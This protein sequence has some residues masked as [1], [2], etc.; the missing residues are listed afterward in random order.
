V[1]V[2]FFGQKPERSAP[3]VSTAQVLRAQGV[4][5]VFEEPP[6]RNAREWVGLM[7]IVDV[8]ICT[9]YGKWRRRAR[10]IL[11]QARLAAVVGTPLLRW[12][13]GSDVW[14]AIRDAEIRQSAKALDRFVA[15]NV[16]VS[17]HLRDEL[18]QLGIASRV[19][20]RPLPDLPQAIDSHW[21]EVR[22][23]SVLVY[24]PADRAAS[25]GA[26][27]LDALIPARQDLT[28]YLVA[29]A[30]QRYRGAANVVSLGWIQDMEEAYRQTG[31]LMRLRKH[32]GLSRMV[33]EALAR[34]LYVIWSEPFEGC[35]L[36]RTYQEVD[37]ALSAVATQ[38]ALNQDG[39]KVMQRL[40]QPELF[41]QHF[42][43]L[44]DEVRGRRWAKAVP[45]AV[46]LVP[47]LPRGLRWRGLLPALEQEGP[48]KEKR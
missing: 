13:V 14:N 43:A 16:V 36:A 44:V 32:D 1:R 19:I 18:A 34:G 25:Y 40:N 20:L 29:D 5:A 39:I 6:A 10:R 42:A 11:I 37:A 35:I 33:R 30:G 3:A 47:D 26:H 38:R 22:A 17:S 27:I 41:M 45:A 4:E 24:L 7:S 31:C 9:F 8:A 21:D 48:S 12:W 23:R 28:F 46:S 15:A 2:L